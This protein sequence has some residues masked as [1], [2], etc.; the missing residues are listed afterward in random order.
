MGRSRAPSSP[1]TALITIGALVR[2]ASIV[3][4][5]VV[6]LEVYGA[7]YRD[8]LGVVEDEVYVVSKR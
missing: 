2:L 4:F 3:M 7:I 8:M 1:R 6:P 5:E